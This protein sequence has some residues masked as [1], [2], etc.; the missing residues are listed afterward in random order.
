MAGVVR[1]CAA[2]SRR[3]G[4]SLPRRPTAPDESTAATLDRRGSP[5]NEALSAWT[6][7]PTVEDFGRPLPETQPGPFGALVVATDFGEITNDDLWRLSV[8][9]VVT[10]CSVVA[11]YGA[12]STRAED[13]FDEAAVIVEIA[14]E[15]NVE[16]RRAISEDWPRPLE[17]SGA[18]R[19]GV[20]FMSTS[21]DPTHEP[22]GEIITRYFT[23]GPVKNQIAIPLDPRGA[24]ALHDALREADN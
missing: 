24:A 20:G 11:Y 17:E 6:L 8:W 5:I 7:L 4:L 2:R 15:G 10:G 14:L 21:H 1:P 9:L 13:L 19:W 3:A 18:A 22:L 23:S 16:M 12:Q